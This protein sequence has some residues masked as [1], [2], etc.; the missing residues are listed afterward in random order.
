MKK[1]RSAGSVNRDVAMPSP[2]I[3]GLEF[4]WKPLDHLTNALMFHLLIIE[5]VEFADGETFALG[6]THSQI[7]VMPRR[8]GVIC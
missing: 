5:Y 8:V 6:S 2:K 7:A 1:L 4:G 3:V